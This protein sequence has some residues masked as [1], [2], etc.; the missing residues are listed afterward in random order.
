MSDHTITWTHGPHANV[1]A[2]VTCQAPQDA[3]CRTI[4][5]DP[6]QPWVSAAMDDDVC[7]VAALINDGDVFEAW[8]SYTHE[9]TTPVRN[10]PITVKA[11]WEPGEWEWDY[12]AQPPTV[13]D[14]VQAELARQDAK[15]NEQNHPDGTGGATYRSLSNVFRQHCDLAT[16]QGQLTWTDILREEVHEAFAEDDPQLLRAELIQVAAVAVQ[17]IGALDRRTQRVAP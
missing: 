8:E 14:Q 6:Q 13:L 1:H 10:G 3:P 9:E 11:G 15:W 4:T 2:V 17:W 16:A 7:Y 5:P 12:A